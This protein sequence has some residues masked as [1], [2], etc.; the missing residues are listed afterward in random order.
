MP[1]EHAQVEAGAVHGVHRVRGLHGLRGQLRQQR[2][3]RQSPRRVRARAARQRVCQALSHSYAGV[4]SVVFF[5]TKRIGIHL[6]F[7]LFSIIIISKSFL[8]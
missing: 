3:A 5:L 2:A 7:Y 6:Q 8:F 1:P 4:C